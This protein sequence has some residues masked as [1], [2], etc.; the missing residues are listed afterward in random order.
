MISVVGTRPRATAPIAGCAIASSTAK[1]TPMDAIKAMMN[2]SSQR[3][4]LF[5]SM[6]ISSTSS[7]V[8][9]TPQ[10]SGMPNSR[11]S[12]IAAP[13]T[14]ARSQAAIAISQRIQSTK[15]TGRE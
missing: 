8:S 11:L 3:N 2:A 1:H 7:A 13:I 4:P 10:I 14:S 5:W 15:L 6:R 12:A 9:T